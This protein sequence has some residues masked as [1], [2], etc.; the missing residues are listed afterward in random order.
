MIENYLLDVMQPPK[1]ME[2]IKK[3]LTDIKGNFKEQA[4]DW[5]DK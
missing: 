3:A 4:K 5:K 2:T 1:E